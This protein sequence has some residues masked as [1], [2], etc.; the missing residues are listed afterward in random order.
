M[1]SLYEASVLMV[2][3]P[4]ALHSPNKDDI[5]HASTVIEKPETDTNNKVHGLNS[6]NFYS[7][8]T[9]PITAL[10]IIA[11]CISIRRYKYNFAI[12]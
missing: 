4:V 2:A 11:V 8:V 9:C 7:S 3:R 1:A 10:L 5:Y 6:F 12:N